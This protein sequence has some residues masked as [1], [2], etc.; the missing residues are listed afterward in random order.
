MAN[1]KDDKKEDIDFKYLLV[2]I[3]LT[4]ACFLIEIHKAGLI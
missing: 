4:I 2:F 1:H 3:I